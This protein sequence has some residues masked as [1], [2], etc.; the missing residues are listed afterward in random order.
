MELTV[1]DKYTQ[2][3]SYLKYVNKQIKNRI[4]T[5]LMKYYIIFPNTNNLDSVKTFNIYKNPNFN[6]NRNIVTEWITKNIILFLFEKNYYIM[7]FD[8]EDNKIIAY[9]ETPIE[10]DKYK[11]LLEF[12]FNSIEGVEIQI[13][14]EYCDWEFK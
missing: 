12:W 9:A 4:K 7:H 6:S 14:K 2:E 5:L 10:V 11:P 3:E 13:V 8:I 1:I